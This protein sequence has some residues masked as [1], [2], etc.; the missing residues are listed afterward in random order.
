M[1]GW[2][3]CRVL[4]RSIGLLILLLLA[5]A[6]RCC[7]DAVDAVAVMTSDRR[8]VL[9]T[10]AASAMRAEVFGLVPLSRLSALLFNRSS[11]VS[12]SYSEPSVPMLLFRRWAV[13]WRVDSALARSA[14]SSSSRSS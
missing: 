10:L 5:D 14:R 6:R 1:R 13:D 9:A 3:C 12:S 7:G 11:S 2:R 4:A 8:Q